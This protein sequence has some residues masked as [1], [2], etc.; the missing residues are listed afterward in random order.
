VL[1]F[2]GAGH[3]KRCWP[4]ERFLCLAHWLQDI[5][6]RPLFVLGPAETERGID[7]QNFERAAPA[8]LTELQAC[9]ETAKLAVGNDSG[10]LHL[11]GY[12]QTPCLA[13]FGPASP[14]QWGPYGVRTLWLG[15]DC[16]PCT[17]RGRMA[18]ESA[19]CLRGIGLDKVQKEVES[20]LW[21]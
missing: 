5:G 20:L 10:P 19:D 21:G 3:A 9:L 1:L 15:L 13:L 18:C 4:L 8:D 14:Q 12:C 7:V 6:E 17:D 11:A 16:S 2:P